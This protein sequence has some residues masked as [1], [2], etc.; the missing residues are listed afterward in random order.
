MQGAEDGGLGQFLAKG[1]AEFDRGLDPGALDCLP[2]FEN[3][4]RDAACAG[5]GGIVLPA[6]V[7]TQGKDVG[8]VF[9]GD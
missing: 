3:Q 9:G 7:A 8:E 2:H 1:F 6:F 4:G 5:G